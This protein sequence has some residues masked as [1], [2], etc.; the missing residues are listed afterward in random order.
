MR[1]TYAVSSGKSLGEQ[2]YET[3]RDAIIT[4][5]L[6]PGQ[7]I[8]ENELADS[9]HISRTPIRDALQRLVSERLVDILPQRSKRVAYISELKVKESS[10]V[11]LSLE[12]SAFRLAA[13]DWRET[14]RCAKAEKQI[15]RLLREQS[16]AAEQQDVAEFLLLDEEFHRCILQLAGNE[17]LLEVVYHMRGHLN[18]FRY[19]AMKELVLTGSL[20]HEHEE[21]FER[22]KKRDEDGVV[23]LLEH[24]LGKLDS[25]FPRLRE[26]FPGYFKD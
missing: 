10:F 4:L 13:G 6:E 9:L 5:R 12:S 20:V 22:L 11:R 26:Q 21:L 1:F 24:H 14:E 18:R 17:T 16:E 19:L 3:I 15:A 8:Y 2:A 23:K 25:E 7:T